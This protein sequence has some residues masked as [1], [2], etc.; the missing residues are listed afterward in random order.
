MG[1]WRKTLKFEGGAGG[2]G[3]ESGA[4]LSGSGLFGDA[5]CSEDTKITSRQ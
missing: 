5:L 4:A 3:Q 1:A 2:G